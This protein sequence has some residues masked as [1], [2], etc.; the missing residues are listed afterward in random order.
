MKQLILTFFLVILCYSL[1]FDKKTGHY[2]NDVNNY[3]HTDAN[4]LLAPYMVSDT[5]SSISTLELFENDSYVYYPH[6]ESP[7]Y[8]H[9]NEDRDLYRLVGGNRSFN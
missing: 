1:F 6:N 5:V 9:E 2:T 8:S 7:I 4:I 3:I